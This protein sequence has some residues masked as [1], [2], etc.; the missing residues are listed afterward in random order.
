M[1]KEVI[2][3]KHLILGFKKLDRYITISATAQ[4]KDKF[5]GNSIYHCISNKKFLICFEVGY[6]S[7]I[8]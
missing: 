1:K 3:T 5:V 2:W 4:K 8:M 7:S 6:K